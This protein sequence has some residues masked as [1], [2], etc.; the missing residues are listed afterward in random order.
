MLRLKKWHYPI[1][2]ALLIFIIIVQSSGNITG[3]I[4]DFEDVEPI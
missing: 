1:V 4:Y 2:R 3:E